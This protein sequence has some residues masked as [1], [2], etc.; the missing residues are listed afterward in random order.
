MIPEQVE[1]KCGD[2]CGGCDALVEAI[3]ELH[4]FFRV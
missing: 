4:M 2:E 1:C 3:K